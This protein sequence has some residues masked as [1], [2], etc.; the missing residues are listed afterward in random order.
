MAKRFNPKIWVDTIFK[1]DLDNLK[2][3]GIKGILFD[4]DNTLV[5][6]S[7][8]QPDEK[9]INWISKIK[10]NGFK[11]GLFSN[12]NKKRVELFNKKL[13]IFSLAKGQKP[14]KIGFNKIAKEME[15]KPNEIAMVGDQI[16]TDIYGGNRF[17]A[18]TIMVNPVDIY[19]PSFIRFKR[20]IEKP[21]LIR[22]KKGE[23]SGYKE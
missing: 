7:T 1:I 22:F 4:I 20:L 10:E 3:Q 18:Y 19:E 23:E 11:V 2:R 9:I 15:L 21:I 12:A 17:G 14:F 6:Y 13:G 16:F 8:P 5:A